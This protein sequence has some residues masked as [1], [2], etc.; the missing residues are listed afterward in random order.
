MMHSVMSFTGLTMQ[1]GQYGISGSVKDRASFFR[2]LGLGYNT[3]CFV[4]RFFYANN[5]VFVG[6]KRRML[7]LSFSMR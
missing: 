2:R 3:F 4:K 5:P 1:R 6:F 7:T